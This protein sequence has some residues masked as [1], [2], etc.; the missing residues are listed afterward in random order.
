MP[1][2]DIVAVQASADAGVVL[3]ATAADPVNFQQTT[4]TGRELIIAHNTGAVARTVTITSA[5]LFGRTKH[6]TSDSIAAGARE[7]FGPFPV[8]GWRQDDGNLYFQ[9][10]NAEVTFSVIRLPS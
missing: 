5:P 4:H 3:T 7:V 1:R 8:A 9:A 6:I 10:D 2:V